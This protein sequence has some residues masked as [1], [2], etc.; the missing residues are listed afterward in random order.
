MQEQIRQVGG[1]EPEPPASG[2]VFSLRPYV[3]G[4]VKCLR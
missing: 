2:S 1:C 4:R 3:I